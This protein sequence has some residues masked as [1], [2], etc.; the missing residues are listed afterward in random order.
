M[1]ST[2]IVVLMIVVAGPVA[3]ATLTAIGE[4]RRGGRLGV[5]VVAGLFFPLAWIAWYARDQ[6]ALDFGAHEFLDLENEALEDGGSVDLVFDV[7][8]GDVQKRS[9][10][11][12]SGRE[13][14][15]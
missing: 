6:K 15:W 12:W 8:G 2:G 10:R 11:P 9:L 7:L 1:T 13:G 4:R 14:R 3:L 5:A